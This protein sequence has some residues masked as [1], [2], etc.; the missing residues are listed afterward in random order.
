MAESG[1]RPLGPN[2]HFSAVFREFGQ[3]IGLYPSPVWKM[4]DLLL[5]SEFGWDPADSLRYLFSFSEFL[6]KNNFVIHCIYD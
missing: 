1:T 5:I 6:G 4:L 3:M 2:F